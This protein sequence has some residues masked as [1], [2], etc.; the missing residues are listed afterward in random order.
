ML[1][2]L[3]SLAALIAY[4]LLARGNIWLLLAG[5]Y[6]LCHLLLSFQKLFPLLFTGRQRT[7]RSVHSES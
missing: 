3:P 4:L 1:L 2:R 6:Q 7:C 5:L